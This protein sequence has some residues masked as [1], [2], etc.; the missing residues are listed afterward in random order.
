MT[1]T[2]TCSPKSP[3]LTFAGLQ[4]YFTDITFYLRVCNC[5]NFAAS[6]HVVFRNQGPV[7]VKLPVL[8]YFPWFQLPG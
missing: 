2:D 4:V 3:R 5:E 6:R 8:T 1:K 7:K